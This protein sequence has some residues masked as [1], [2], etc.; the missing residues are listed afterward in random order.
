[1]PT[2]PGSARW[3]SPRSLPPPS[4]R[5]GGA[6]GVA[7][8][9]VGVAG[10]AVGAPNGAAR[11]AGGACVAVPTG[12]GS[13]SSEEADVQEGCEEQEDCLDKEQEVVR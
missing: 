8:G 9:A 6:V 1:M 5:A 12:S 3:N 2:W 11:V 4:F 10:G 7:G 13:E